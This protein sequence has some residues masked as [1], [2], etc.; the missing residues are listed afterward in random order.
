M[1]PTRDKTSL[2]LPL[3]LIIVGLTALA[4]LAR[5]I[6]YNWDQW[7][8]SVTAPVTGQQMVIAKTGMV[9]AANQHASRVGIDILKKG[10]NAVDAAVAAAFSLGIVEPFASGIGGG[11]FMLIYLAKTHEVIVI[12]Y[13]EIAPRAA[14]GPAKEGHYAV[15]IPGTV[16]G[17]ALAL[18]NY[19]T[20]DI[21]SVM[22]PSIQ[23]AENGYE[24]SGLLNRMMEGNSGKLLKNPA[25]AQIFLKDG[26]PYKIGERLYLKDLAG[27]YRQIAE[28]G[29][30]IFYKGAIAEAIVKEMEGKGMLTLEDMKSYHPVLRQAVKGTYRGYEIFAMGPPSSGGT[31][32]IELLNILERFDMAGFGPDNPEGIRIMADAMT[33]VFLDREKFMGDPDFVTVP[34]NELLSKKYAEKLSL[35]IIAGKAAAS[36][37]N[38]SGYASDQTSHLSVIDGEGNMV[39]LTQTINSF[40]GSGVVAPGTGILL[41]NEM[42]DFD[43]QGGRPNSVKPWKRPLSSMSPTLVLKDGK[44]Y[45]TIGM[46]GATRII[47]YCRKSL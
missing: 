24:V 33:R 44:P 18:K 28:N 5:I 34:L 19:G 2:K 32:I 10:G 17:L 12:D 37:G 40:F 46:P 30:D 23:I 27:T 6:I 4:V 39:A 26:L 21:K 25:A 20:M 29:P 13:R 1:E 47:P 15:A 14:T 43:P 41:N 11:G 7:R 35:E 16:A 38:V 9:A 8:Q 31:H 45:M 3:F 42:N 22:E 36:A